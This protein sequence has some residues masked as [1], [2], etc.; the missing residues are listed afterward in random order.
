MEK[1]FINYLKRKGLSDRTVKNYMYYFD[2]ISK[3]KITEELI[4]S[5]LDEFDNCVSRGF[6]N[7]YLGFMKRRDIEIPRR[8]GAKKVRLPTF[9]NESEII[10]L[11][12]SMNNSRN[13]IMVELSFQ[14]G[15]RPSEL[16]NIKL[17]HF[18]WDEWIEEKG[19]GKLL[20]I[21]KRNK[22]RIVH[23][24]PSLMEDL[25]N[26]IKSIEK[27]IS[28]E[29]PI[30]RISLRRWDAIINNKSRKIFG[31][32]ISPHSL[33][34][35]CATYLLKMK[36]DISKI[37]KYLGHENVST[38]QIYVHINPEDIEEDFKEIF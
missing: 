14:G 32:T 25:Y 34:H 28:E 9:L 18:N 10:K 20:V 23:I 13:R 3:E 4:N 6:V 12:E 17:Y 5:F 11:I 27:E 7:N 19:Y 35:S 30:F 37:A 16:L 26:Y 33:R 2:R 24:N 36:W 8:T 31:K 21:G 22:E 29:D 38:T 15:L 1:E